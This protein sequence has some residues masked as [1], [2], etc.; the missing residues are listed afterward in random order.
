[1]V[2]VIKVHNGHHRRCALTVFPVCVW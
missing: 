2:N 1:M